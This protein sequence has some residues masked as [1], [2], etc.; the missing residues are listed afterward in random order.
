MSVRLRHHQSA[1]VIALMPLAIFFLLGVG[2]LAFDV[3]RYYVTRQ[4]LQNLAE[5]AAVAAASCYSASD[6]SDCPTDPINVATQVVQEQASN[7]PNDF[8]AQDQP[9]SLTRVQVGGQPP[10]PGLP[11]PSSK[12]A[13]VAISC[14][15]NL[16]ILNLLPDAVGSLSPSVQVQAASEWFWNVNPQNQNQVENFLVAAHP[17]ATG[18]TT[19]VPGFLLAEAITTCSISSPS[20]PTSTGSAPSHVGQVGDTVDCQTVVIDSRGKLVPNSGTVNRNVISP[21]QPPS[22]SQCDLATTCGPNPIPIPPAAFRL[23]SVG[24]YVVSATLN[25]L[26]SGWV[27]GYQGPWVIVVNS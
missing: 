25:S 2:G 23:T 22:M 26:P 7:L 11:P 19:A 24:R 9:P 14:G 20:I 10:T 13:V 15:M 16:T 6:W 5:V 17:V 8:C 3:G 4:H 1:Q 21:D 18:S 12:Q 27:V